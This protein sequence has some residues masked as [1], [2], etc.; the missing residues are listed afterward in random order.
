MKSLTSFGLI[1]LAVAL[2]FF[3]IRPEYGTVSGLMAQK[4]D[5]TDVLSKAKS[6]ATTRDNLLSQYNSISP[7]DKTKLENMI[8]A[9]F[10]SV[11]LV[12]DL[13][14]IGARYGLS[15]KGV[16]IQEDIDTSD[17]SRTDVAST[18]EVQ[19]YKTALI[20]FTVSGTYA[21]FVS[22]LKDVE[23]SQE[24][25]DVK[26]LDISP[27]NLANGNSSTLNIQVVLNTYYIN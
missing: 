8:P 21:N 20:S 15:L 3:Y 19:A 1:I 14:A 18:P 17:Q 11:K 5:Y 9:S 10:N 16:S 13:S 4:S 12:S 26:K 27:A 22:F 23:S 7:D 2:F 25:M 24:L 6:L